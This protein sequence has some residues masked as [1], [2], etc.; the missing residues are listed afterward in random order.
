MR[1]LAVIAG[2][3]CAIASA[4]GCAS[5]SDGS[6]GAES[7]SPATTGARSRSFGY[8]HSV[9][10]PSS[11]PTISFDR[12]QFLTGPAANEAAV[13]DGRIATSDTV[14]NDYYIRNESEDVEKLPIATAVRVTAVRCPTSCREGVAGD[15]D[16]LAA[17]FSQPGRRSLNDDYRGAQS[18][19]WITVEDGVVVRI[20]EQ[21]LP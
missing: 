3:V 13:E 10:P 2:L 11:P 19:Y 15:F 1:S 12:A 21:Y 7:P 9:D 18:Q 5:A 14:P 8:I 20:D 17:S 16:A 6:A 4:V